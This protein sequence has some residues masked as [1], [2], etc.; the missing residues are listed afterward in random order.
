M[1][2]ST[3][4]KIKVKQLSSKTHEVEVTCDTTVLQL[5][6]KLEKLSSIP[7]VDIKLIFKGKILK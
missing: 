7:A 3:P 5:K 4:Y 1:T 2:E 6:E